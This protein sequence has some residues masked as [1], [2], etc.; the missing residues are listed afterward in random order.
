MHGMNRAAHRPHALLYVFSQIY[1]GII[2]LYMYSEQVLRLLFKSFFASLH[3]IE[4]ALV[5]LCI[6]DPLGTHNCWYCCCCCCC[7]ILYILSKFDNST[8][9]FHSRCLVARLC[10][11][12]FLLF[13]LDTFSSSGTVFCRVSFS[14][15]HSQFE[16]IWKLHIL[17][18]LCGVRVLVGLVRCRAFRLSD[19]T[20]KIYWQPFRLID[21]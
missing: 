17:L 20:I 14:A 19:S 11:V 3:I 4:D 21:S 7:S 13:S 15:F 5:L 6:S 9:F 8:F 12:L 2:I 10:L 16:C 18:C 1:P